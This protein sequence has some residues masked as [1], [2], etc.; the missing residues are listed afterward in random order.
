LVVIRGRIRKVIQ[1]DRNRL[2]VIAW[3]EQGV[4]VAVHVATLMRYVEARGH[5]S[6]L[7]LVVP[8]GYEVAMERIDAAARQVVF[9]TPGDAREVDLEG[10]LGERHGMV[11]RARTVCGGIGHVRLVVCTVEVHAIPAAGKY[12]GRV[13]R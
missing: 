9:R 8:V 3:P 2:W 1:V 6:V 10:D 11:R 5:E 12:E 7:Y 4:A 13:D